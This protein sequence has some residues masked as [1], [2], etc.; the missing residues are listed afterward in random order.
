MGL[1]ELWSTSTVS[2]LSFNMVKRMTY[3]LSWHLYLWGR[4]PWSRNPLS[5]LIATGNPALCIKCLLSTRDTSWAQSI[6]PVLHFKR[7]FPTIPFH[8]LICFHSLDN[9]PYCGFKT[10]LALSENLPD[11]QV[12]VYIYWNEPLSQDP[13]DWYLYTVEHHSPRETIA[14]LKLKEPS[15]SQIGFLLL[16]AWMVNSTGPAKVISQNKVLWESKECMVRESQHRCLLMISHS[17][18]LILLPTKV[19]C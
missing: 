6:G 11:P 8:F 16:M 9:Y 15:I 14:R 10:L 18:H 2:T 4:T 3:Y 7:H 5:N 12:A 17:F 1:M 19:S 13:P